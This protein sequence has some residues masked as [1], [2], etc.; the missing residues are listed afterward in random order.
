[1]TW[2]L[3]QILGMM[4]RTFRLLIF[5]PKEDYIHLIKYH[6]N[7]KV[8]RKRDLL[9]GIFEIFGA[10]T[11]EEIEEQLE[12]RIGIVCEAL[13]LG[14]TGRP[15]IKTA[16]YE[17]FEEKGLFEGKKDWPTPKEVMDRALENTKSLRG[18]HL[19]DVRSVIR[20]RFGELALSPIFKHGKG[21]RHT[22]FQEND[23]DIVT[24]SFSRVERDLTVN[25][26]FERSFTFN[27]VNNIR[28]IL[29]LLIILEE[30]D[31][32]FNINRE[33]SY[34][35]MP[36]E[37]QKWLFQQSREM[38]IG[39]CA[40]S[41]M[42]NNVTEFVRM[43]AA[44][45]ITLKTQGYNVQIAQETMG[46]SDEQADYLFKLAEHGEAIIRLPN[47]KDPLLV[48]IE[49]DFFLE[50]DVTREFIDEK[51]RK[52]LADEYAAIGYDPDADNI[53]REPGPPILDFSQE[54]SDERLKYAIL[55]VINK[56]HFQH[57]ADI[58]NKIKGTMTLKKDQFDR[59]IDKLVEAELVKKTGC[60]VYPKKPM[61]FYP[62]TAKAQAL[63]KVNKG[64]PSI[65]RHSYYR[66]R[67]EQFLKLKQWQVTCEKKIYDKRVDV[68]AEKDGK[69]AAFEITLSESNLKDNIEN[70]FNI[71]NADEVFIVCE[72]AENATR[73]KQ[74]MRGLQPDILDKT[75]FITI[76]DFL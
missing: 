10:K 16:V 57:H 58:R 51:M 65:F 40:L 35:A 68:Y 25:L 73:A 61:P 46:L 76:E 71:F 22:F 8:L 3:H 6:P 54:A 60:R 69:I 43:N 17:L 29:T 31:T 2:I 26:L 59:V 56:D 64:D 52:P 18:T 13:Y 27:M 5:D 4:D 11:R 33:N 48:T 37:E 32:I 63:M 67:V 7:L 47:Y 66:H 44:T 15:I 62:L 55:D 36:A 28:N 49:C 34:R 50:K 72:F 39:T 20:E 23:V 24:S 1:M 30:A 70:C 53:E 74:K 41:Q 42:F 38:G 21:F 14:P 12:L 9:L 75:K 45:V 19:G